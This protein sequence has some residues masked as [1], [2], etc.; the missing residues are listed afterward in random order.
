MTMRADVN[1]RFVSTST[2]LAVEL[3]LS[4]ATGLSEHVQA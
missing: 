4:M 1:D 3:L 2:A